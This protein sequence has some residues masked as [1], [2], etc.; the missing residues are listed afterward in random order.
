[1]S[2]GK[3]YDTRPLLLA[4]RG[5]KPQREMLKHAFRKECCNQKRKRIYQ[6]GEIKILLLITEKY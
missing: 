5:K 1:L 2:G 3:S 4:W 6:E